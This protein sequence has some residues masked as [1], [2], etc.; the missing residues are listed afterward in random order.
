[1]R[2]VE[3]L[4]SGNEFMQLNDYYGHQAARPDSTT[5]RPLAAA[6][7]TPTDV[8]SRCTKLQ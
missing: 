8:A 2:S 3:C 4:V 6:E 7:R 1:M 5:I